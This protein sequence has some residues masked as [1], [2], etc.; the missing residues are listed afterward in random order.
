VRRIYVRAI[1][2][3]AV[4]AGL[5][6]IVLNTRPESALEKV[7]D[8]SRLQPENLPELLQRIRDFHRTVTRDGKKLLE[9]SAKEASYFRGE[10]AVE[11]LEPK[12]VFFHEGEPVVSV[13][14]GRGYLMMDGNEIDA[15][16]LSGKVELQLSKFR[17]N[18][19]SIEYLRELDRIFTVGATLV[20]S[21]E[22][23]L[24]GT[25]LSFDLGQK[26]L[27]VDGDVDLVL[28][29]AADVSADRSRGLPKEPS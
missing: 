9:V 23:E 11:I 19:E 25:D 3:A 20:T 22:L 16:E 15:V 28:Q 27:N 6:L 29:P 24:R 1:F 10:R 13:S 14:G 17:I 12:V 18:A 8:L 5:A 26:T 2:L 7:L 4:A 21:P